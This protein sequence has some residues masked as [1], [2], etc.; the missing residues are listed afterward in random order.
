[1]PWPRWLHLT[2]AWRARRPV[3]SPAALASRS[4][5]AP[6]THGARTGIVEGMV[7]R[8]PCYRDLKRQL[9]ELDALSECVEL[10]TRELVARAGATPDQ[11]AYLGTQS[12]HHGIRVNKLDV[13]SIRPHLARMYILTVHQCLEDFLL[14]MQDEH[15]GGRHWDMDDKADRPR[16]DRATKIARAVRF[17][18]TLAFEICQHYRAIRNATMHPSARAKL[19]A[20]GETATALQEQVNRDPSLQRLDAP[21]GYD[22]VTFDDFVLFSRS[23]KTLAEELCKAAQPTD[24]EMADDV[25]T[26]TKKLAGKLA[27][28]PRRLAKARSGFLRTKYSLSEAEAD[29][30]VSGLLA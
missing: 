20:S 2:S 27:K 19:L 15:P 7:F 11:H 10:A 14:R 5:T 25:T 24:D 17:K 16:E 28:N 23:A 9:G 1:M 21:K 30:I 3:G 4:R 8:F 6:G 18:H 22:A 26:M 29:R 13:P 12:E